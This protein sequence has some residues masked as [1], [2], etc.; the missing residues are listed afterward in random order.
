MLFCAVEKQL[1]DI[2]MHDIII[3]VDVS[4]ALPQG[5]GGNSLFNVYDCILYRSLYM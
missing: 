2:I 3:T 1:N 4:R 5:L